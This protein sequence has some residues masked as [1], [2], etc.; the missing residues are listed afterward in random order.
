MQQNSQQPYV[1][2]LGQRCIFRLKV[3]NTS[4]TNW[5]TNQDWISY[6]LNDPHEYRICSLV[7]TDV[8][9]AP[10]W[11]YGTITGSR[12]HS[13]TEWGNGNPIGWSGQ[14]AAKAKKCSPRQL[15]LNLK[16]FLTQDE[17]ELYEMC[18]YVP[19]FLTSLGVCNPPVPAYMYR[20]TNS[21]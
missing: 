14:W 2:N 19:W 4:P 8:E 20:L 11:V 16:L 7:L 13:T 17:N 12:D 10:W 5:S 6:I 21:I 9:P 15:L 1:S 18:H 3:R